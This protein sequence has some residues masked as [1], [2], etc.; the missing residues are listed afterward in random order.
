MENF[1]L[2]IILILLYA[3]F[4]KAQTPSYAGLPDS[5]HVLVVY[6]FPSNPAD[7]ISR[8]VMN[9]YKNARHIPD[10]NIVPLNNLVNDDIY[11]PVSNT[12]HNVRIVQQGEII[13]DGN[14][15]DDSVAVPTRHSWIY[16]NERIAKPIAEY[17][18][19][20]IVIGEP[21]FVHNSL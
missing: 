18:K 19:T 13:E 17:L 10:E 8:A 11:D 9:Y 2:L 21:S 20:T 12:T 5:S 16:F 3:S 6:Q 4:A 15:E 7:T 1:W 14:N